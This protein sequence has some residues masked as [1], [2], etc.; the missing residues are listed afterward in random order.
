[1]PHLNELLIFTA[2][3][4][5][6]NIE[7]RKNECENFWCWMN[8]LYNKIK[9]TIQNTLLVTVPEE[10]QESIRK[11]M[12]LSNLTRL[13]IES[14]ILII[15]NLITLIAYF[16]YY[17]SV[18]N[19]AYHHLFTIAGVIFLMLFMNLYFSKCMR[20]NVFLDKFISVNIT[21]IFTVIYFICEFV[22]FA[23]GIRDVAA[24]VRFCAVPF[25]IGSVPII[26]QSRAFLLNLSAYIISCYYI[27]VLAPFPDFTPIHSII[28]NIWIDAFVCSLIISAAIYSSFVNNYVVNARLRE[29]S[30]RTDQLAKQDQLTGINNRRKLVQFMDDTWEEAANKNEIITAMMIDIDYFKQYNDCFGHLVGDECLVKV[31]VA[32]QNHIVMKNSIFARYGGEEFIV[33]AFGEEHERMVALADQMRL[34]IENLK[35]KNPNSSVSPYVTVSIGVSSFFVGSLK[36]AQKII[37]IVDMSLY[38]AKRDG[39]NR[40]IHTCHDQDAFMDVNGRSLTQQQLLQGELITYTDTYLSKIMRD[41]AT[42][43]YFMYHVNTNHTNANHANTNHTDANHAN[44]NHVNANHVNSNHSNTNHSNSLEFSKTATELYL[45]PKSIL[46]TS[47]EKVSKY[48]LFDY[49]EDFLRKMHENIERRS[50][51]FSIRTYLYSRRNERKLVSLELKMVYDPAGNV[52]MAV[53]FIANLE[54]MIQYNKFIQHESMLDSITLLPNRKKFT[55]DMV[56]VLKSASEGYIVFMDIVR[57]KLINSMYSHNIG[58]KAL[59]NI[60]RLLKRLTAHDGNIYCYTIDQF[61]VH[62][63]NA[64]YE[65]TLQ[66]MEKVYQYFKIHPVNLDGIELNINLALAA[67]EYGQSSRSFD[68]V[69]L[70]LDITMQKAKTPGNTPYMFF[71]DIDRERHLWDLNIEQQLNQSIKN[72]FQGFFMHYQPIVHA[73][74]KNIIGAE[75]LLRWESLEG[76]IIPSLIIVSML[77]K[78][79]QMAK[80]ES[81]IF[82]QVCRQCKEWIA[83]G[84][85]LEIFIQVNLSASQIARESLIHELNQAI[86]ENG[87]RK[88]NIVLEVTETSLMMNMKKTIETLQHLQNQGIRIAVDDFGTGYSSLSYLRDLPVDEIKIDKSFL[89]NIE[90]DISARDILISIVDLAKSMGYTVCVEGIEKPEQLQYLDT[91]PIDYYQGYLFSKPRSPEDFAK[92]VKTDFSCVVNE[93]MHV[94]QY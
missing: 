1:M 7:M 60:G 49:Q 56:G 93:R 83:S 68:E 94:N 6:T 61:M 41:T 23:S 48:I 53:G 58:D 22:I 80:M 66:Y 35:I 29:L 52:Q 44:T 86:E 10:Y 40:V 65:K 50:A 33:L 14:F 18:G 89:D 27:F 11:P 13:F 77:E 42:N 54:Q 76:E 32:I 85:S 24:F 84:F 81:W 55:L 74:N 5:D 38:R 73:K 12:Y 90:N 91:L 70:D 87:I 36:N 62:M 30:N 79:E 20:K 26:K 15:I 78:N 75:A 46:K 71:S 88:E 57:F 19:I 43:C 3:N 67:T 72:G 31:S 51:E 69:M 2:P 82:E 4:S 92:N 63:P 17:M 8:I 47:W 39:R 25:V 37:E 21:V 28:S 9:E 59:Y 16:T 64:T 34:D 45:L